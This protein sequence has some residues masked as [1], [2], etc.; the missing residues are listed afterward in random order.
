VLSG[1][2]S[3]L[4]RDDVAGD[5]PVDSA[6]TWVFAMGGVGA[7]VLLATSALMPG[8]SLLPEGLRQP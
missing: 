3:E 1:S 6:Y 5:F 7:A 4:E 8:R 2:A